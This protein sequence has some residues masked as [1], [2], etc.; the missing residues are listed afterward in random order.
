MVMQL[1]RTYFNSPL[2]Y[3][4]TREELLACYSH[5]PSRTNSHA[6]LQVLRQSV[7]CV[8]RL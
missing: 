1:R 2:S 5:I 6:F 8:R 7:L 3:L 4:T